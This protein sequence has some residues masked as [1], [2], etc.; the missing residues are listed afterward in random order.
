MEVD[1]DGGA[2]TNFGTKDIL[3]NMEEQRIFP[4]S[5]NIGNKTAAL[6]G[7]APGTCQLQS[8]Y[9]IKFEYD[10]MSQCTLKDL[11]LW[12]KGKTDVVESVFALDNVQYCNK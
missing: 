3:K 1:L 6:E 9:N 7:V 4:S 10:Y 8:I 11:G 5:S 2:S 12:E